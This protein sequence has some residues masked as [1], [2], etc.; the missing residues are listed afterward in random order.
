MGSECHAYRSN[1]P[2]ALYTMERPSTSISTC[3]AEIQVEII[4]V[5]DYD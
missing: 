1:N 5:Y 4:A 3:S 2:A